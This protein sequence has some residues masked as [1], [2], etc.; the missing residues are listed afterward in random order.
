MGSDASE[1]KSEARLL[2]EHEGCAASWFLLHESFLLHEEPG[3]RSTFGRA[4]VP[5]L[6]TIGPAPELRVIRVGPLLPFGAMSRL[7]SPPAAKDER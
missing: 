5:A 3:E 7:R 4:E 2:R 6:G 1:A